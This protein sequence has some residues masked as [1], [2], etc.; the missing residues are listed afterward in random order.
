MKA[1]HFDADNSTASQSSRAGCA[2]SPSGGRTSSRE[3]GPDASRTKDDQ[4]AY[5]ARLGCVWPNDDVGPVLN[6]SYVAVRLIKAL[7]SHP[8][9]DQERR[10]KGLAM[11]EGGWGDIPAE[12]IKFVPAYSPEELETF[13]RELGPR[14]LLAFYAA[15][16]YDVSSLSRDH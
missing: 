2:G 11:L 9:L 6:S 13:L 10:L 7:V 12:R 14:G 5:W 4:K 3:D 15:D 8:A 16:G 1:T